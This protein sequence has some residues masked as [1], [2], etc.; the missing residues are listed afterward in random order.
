MRLTT[1]KII[2]VGHC[3]LKSNDLSSFCLFFTHPTIVW[4]MKHSVQIFLFE[5]KKKILLNII[6]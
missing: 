3:P 5:K 4:K 6:K 1:N 2:L